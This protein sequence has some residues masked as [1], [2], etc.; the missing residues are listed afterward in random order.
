MKLLDSVARQVK[1]KTPVVVNT[2]KKTVKKGKETAEHA[3]E[4]TPVVNKVVP[5]AAKTT[6]NTVDLISYKV[7]QGALWSAEKVSSLV[8][9]FRKK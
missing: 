4:S 7:A 2:T 1:Q 8:G 6:R 5:A 9:I 3:I